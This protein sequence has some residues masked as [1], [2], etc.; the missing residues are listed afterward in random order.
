MFNRW[1]SRQISKLNQI[2][3]AFAL[4]IFSTSAS[5]QMEL[6][7]GVYT[8][9]KPTTMVKAYRPI[10]SALENVLTLELNEPVQI[11]LQVASSY[12]KGIDALVTG[13]VDFSMIGPA[14]YIE[15]SN[16]EPGL[17]ILALDSSDGAKSFVRGVICVREDSQINTI[18]EL[19]GK[20]FAFGN[21]KSTIGRYLS[22]A[23]LTREGVTASSLQSFDYLGRHDRVAHAVSQATHDAGALKESTYHKLNK[24][25]NLGLRILT[26]ISTIN[27]PWVAS[28][29]LDQNIVDALQSGML[30]LEAPEAFEAMGKK[31]FVRGSDSD[32]AK[33]RSAINNN[34]SF[35]EG[36]PQPLAS[37]EE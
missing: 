19:K 15:A 18:A 9:D 13:E 11:K 4:F 33:I 24:N 36:S 12:Q 30:N 10:L 20:R 2:V 17:Q 7:F 28:A 26:T 25:K 27:R 14:S 35:F 34:D 16:S 22:Q 21:E 5:A 32:F 1:S 23:L 37:A 3:F 6:V 29:Q 31:Q 8:T